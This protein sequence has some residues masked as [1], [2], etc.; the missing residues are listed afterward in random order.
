MLSG[1]VRLLKP[2]PR[3]FELFLETFAIDP[4]C[5]IYID[6]RRPNVD[7]ATAFGMHGILFSDPPFA[8]KF[9]DST[10]SRSVLEPVRG[11]FRRARNPSTGL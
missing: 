9:W 11:R 3:I 4:A 1:E 6:D 7:A 2:D 5:S 10:N 8:V